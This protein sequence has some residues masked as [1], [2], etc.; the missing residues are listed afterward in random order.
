[1]E[2]AVLVRPEE[3]RLSSSLAVARAGVR[4]QRKGRWTRSEPL[5]PTVSAMW[6]RCEHESLLNSIRGYRKYASVALI[7]NAR[8]MNPQRSPPSASPLVRVGKAARDGS[9]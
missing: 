5:R 3:G 2:A 6:R 1:L 8:I 4:Q 9:R 7:M